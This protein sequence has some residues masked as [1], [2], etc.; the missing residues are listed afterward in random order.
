MVG[1]TGREKPTGGQT[2]LRACG[3]RRQSMAG[4]AGSENCRRPLPIRSSD[5]MRRLSYEFGEPQGVVDGEEDRFW[6]NSRNAD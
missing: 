3:C 1:G 4:V 2:D 6:A 5:G